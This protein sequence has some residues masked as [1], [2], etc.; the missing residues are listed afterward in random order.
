MQPTTTSDWP[1]RSRDPR[2]PSYD[3]DEVVLDHT[4]ETRKRRKAARDAQQKAT[5]G[6]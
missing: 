4:L 5:R 3:R 1:A 6:V 2:S